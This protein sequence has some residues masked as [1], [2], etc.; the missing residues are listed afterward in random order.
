V[1][2][3]AEVVDVTR[4][5][6]AT[7]YSLTY[8]LGDKTVVTCSTEDVLGEPV[9][10]DMIQVLYDRE[11]PEIN[12]QSADYGTDFTAPIIFTAAGGVLIAASFGIPLLMRHL[13]A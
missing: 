11:D 7:S 9:R 8:A 2:T 12:C 13:V 10:G 4:V 1:I 6:S 3:T 5:K